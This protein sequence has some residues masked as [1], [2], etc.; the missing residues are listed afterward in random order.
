[1]TTARYNGLFA[2]TL[3]P[4]KANGDVALDH[5][6][7]QVERLIECGVTGLYVCGSTGEGVSLTTAE[8]KA[9]TVE[10]IRA[11]AGRVPVLVQVGHN[12][13]SEAA[14]LAAHAASSGAAGISATC[15]SYFK[16][17]TAGVLVDSMKV[18]ASG[19]AELP[20]YYYHIPSLTG[21]R[22]SMTEF[23]KLGGEAMPNLVGIKYS[24]TELYE[25]Q[26]CIELD[27]GRF[28]IMWG[29]D[30]ML[31]AALAVGGKVAVGSTYNVAAPLYRRLIAAFEQGD[32]A[33][34]RQYQSQAIAF[35]SIVLGYPF[36]SAM[37]HILNWQGCCGESYCRM[38]QQELTL[39]Q[40]TSLHS[41]LAAIG[42]F[43][44]CN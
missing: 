7:P 26:Q 19:A 10:S 34:A 37:K 5:I 22:I 36:Q 27:G 3:T 1:M 31:I 23:L 24:S 11:A 44:W 40:I 16:I 35:I 38:P 43:E 6:A 28:E 32:L 2:A 12:S 13:L 41:R 30:E 29:V 39:E 20:F 25:Y 14:E 9:V 18:V 4:M 42:F 15:P 17:G 21:N 8:R 33:K